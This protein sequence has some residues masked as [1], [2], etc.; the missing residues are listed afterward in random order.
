MISLAFQ[1]S[2][3][4]ICFCPSLAFPATSVPCVLACTLEG[5]SVAGDQICS[6]EATNYGGSE[7]PVTHSC[8]F[9]A[10]EMIE[11]GILEGA[12]PPLV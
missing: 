2:H 8:D 6:T 9:L 7:T 12:L 5:E 10:T 1:P 4:R 11:S 3:C